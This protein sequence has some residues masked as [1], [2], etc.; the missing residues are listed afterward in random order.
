MRVSNSRFSPCLSVAQ[1]RRDESQ[2]NQVVARF[3]LNDFSLDAKRRVV[4]ARVCS[5]SIHSQIVKPP[6]F[7]AMNYPLGLLQS[8]HF[9]KANHTD[10]TERNTKS[11]EALHRSFHL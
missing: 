7:A 2:P 6:A 4:D 5:P 10:F 9:R 8:L 1:S 3:S 11:T